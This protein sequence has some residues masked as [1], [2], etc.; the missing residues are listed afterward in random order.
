VQTTPLAPEPEPQAGA[1]DGGVPVAQGGETERSVDPRVLVVPD[2][3]VRDLE[4]ID[5]G[6]KYLLLRQARPAH[7]ARDAPPDRGQCPTEG[8]HAG[9]LR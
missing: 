8:R 3:Q 5:D 9:V 1:V 2:P 7:V 6:R 4:Q